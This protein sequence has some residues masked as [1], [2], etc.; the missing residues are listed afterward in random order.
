MLYQGIQ[1]AAN[2]AVRNVF[3][4][5]LLILLNFSRAGK[6]LEDG[7]QLN[8]FGMQVVLRVKKCYFSI[9]G[10]RCRFLQCLPLLHTRMKVCSYWY[11]FVSLAFDLGCVAWNLRL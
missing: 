6:H 2:A 4:I 1:A 10:I 5:C 11:T 9:P 8:P 7:I 3:G